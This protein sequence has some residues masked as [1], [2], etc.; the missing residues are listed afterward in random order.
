MSAAA[1][2]IPTVSPAV[3]SAAKHDGH[4][5]MSPWTRTLTDADLP[6][7]YDN[8]CHIVRQGVVVTKLSVDGAEAV[9]PWTVVRLSQ[10]MGASLR[11][12]SLV[13]C[14]RLT[15]AGLETLGSSCRELRHIRLDGCP[16][17]T[18]T[19]F[20]GLMDH[21]KELE[22]LSV[23]GC[24]SF[25]DACVIRVSAAGDKLRA[26]SMA[27]CA[28]ITD[29]ALAAL[30]D[31]CHELRDLD[32]SAGP[33]YTDS[34][35]ISLARGVPQLRR[36][37]LKNPKLSYRITDDFLSLAAEKCPLLEHLDLTGCDA[38]TDVGVRWLA[39]SC[40]G[41]QTLYL[42]GCR[43]IGD[44]G[45]LSIG[46]ALH[47]LR[48][49]SIASCRLVSDIGIRH[50]ADG[51]PLLEHVDL[52]NLILLT[53]GRLKPLPV[54]ARLCEAPA[55]AH[56]FRSLTFEKKAMA[57]EIMLDAS[58]I[59]V[60]SLAH[61]CHKITHLTIAHADNLGTSTARRLSHG[62]AGSLRVLVLTHCRFMTSA[63]LSVLVA[64]SSR[65]LRHLDLRGSTCV[66][67]ASMRALGASC[68][69]LE[70]LNIS[71]CPRL[72][73]DSFKYIMLG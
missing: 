6:K 49:L 8:V 23:D 17:I 63:D 55:Q 31:T 26:M 47:E 57:R 48:R 58:E 9:A 5:N 28:R 38:I 68:R 67:Q 12:I 7:A 72:T 50:L 62:C 64:G 29:L 32:I 16:L 14:R 44:R 66:D 1:P 39:A 10:A 71:G 51:C 65:S 18:A 46:N 24:A 59:G 56:L 69:W 54:S 21:C 4:V 70:M 53:D 33:A 30:G 15:D 34:G 61:A 35:L 60:P 20:S 36:L 40:K 43:Y 25:D 11:E 37:V 27:G 13:N 73:D 3:F 22:S 2:A 41:M 52:S 19:G 42:T 45:M